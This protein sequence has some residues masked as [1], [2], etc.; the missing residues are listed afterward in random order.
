MNSD[1]TI[2][3][4]FGAQRSI[5]ASKEQ[6]VKAPELS[7]SS[8]SE[9]ASFQTVKELRLA[10]VQGERISISDEQLVK[11]IEKAIKAAEGP[12][13]SFDFSIHKETHQIMVKVL[14]KETGELIRE[15]PPEK[16]LDFVAKMWEKAGILIDERR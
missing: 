5:P 12:I 3:G 11:A 10:E 14:N 6:V 9:I 13:T 4:G 8:S 1:L 15:I 2:G 16:T 7:D